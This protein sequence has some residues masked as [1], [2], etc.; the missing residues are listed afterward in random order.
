[1]DPEDITHLFDRFYRGKVGL[2]SGSPGTG[3]GLAIANEILRRHNG[4]LL[5]ES[6]GVSGQG[7]TFTVR[8]PVL[9]DSGEMKK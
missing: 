7:T 9:D 3:L 5:V 8:L 1:V 4:Q 2:E 6:A